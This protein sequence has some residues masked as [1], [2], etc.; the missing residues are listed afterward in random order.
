VFAKTK[1]TRFSFNLRKSW[2]RNLLGLSKPSR[3]PIV[4]LQY[5]GFGT[6]V[7]GTLMDGHLAVGDD[8]EILP[9]V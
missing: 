2:K 3:L 4:R 6:V 1:G 8:V 7:T 5:G 9:P